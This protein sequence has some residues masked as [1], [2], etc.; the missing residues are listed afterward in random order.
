MAGARETVSRV[1][2]AKPSGV[3]GS[4]R[5]RIGGLRY[6]DRPVIKE[7]MQ[8]RER[9]MSEKREKKKKRNGFSK[10]TRNFEKAQVRFTNFIGPFVHLEFIYGI[11]L[12]YTN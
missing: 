10:P 4:S 9:I 6:R 7:A 1:T 5:P 11:I 2:G 8:R 12:H 3:V